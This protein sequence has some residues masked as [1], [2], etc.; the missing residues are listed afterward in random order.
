M[1][2][3]RL[4]VFAQ[5]HL[6]VIAELAADPDVLRF[7][8]FPVPVPSDFADV[9][10]GRLE[11]ARSRN[12]RESFAVV[13]AVDGRVL[14]IAGAPRID[15]EARTVEL[16]YLIAPTARGQGVATQALTMLTAWALEELQA[17]RLELL[18]SVENHASR[19]VAVRC[20]YRLEG[21]L[22]S[23]HLKD[24]LRWDTEIWSRLPN[25]A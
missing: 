9:W 21:V 5:S 24:D 17:L 7:T 25:D 3:V 22:R 4:D 20:G 11:E 2:P 6:G 15:R 18:I 14:G 10:W 12:S 13:G 16:G 23:L 19:Q 8:R 1:V